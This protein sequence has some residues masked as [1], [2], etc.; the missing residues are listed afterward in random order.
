MGMTVTNKFKRVNGRAH[1][2]AGL[3]PRLEGAEIQIRLGHHKLVT[4]GQ[5]GQLTAQKPFP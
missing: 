1:G 3:A 4:P 5:I 2:I